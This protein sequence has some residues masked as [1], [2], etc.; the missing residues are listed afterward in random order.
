[1][2]EDLINEVEA[3]VS[4]YGGYILTRTNKEG[5]YIL[6][7]PSHH[8]SLRLCFPS[9]YPDAPP[10]I[11]GTESVGEG[12]RKGYG[13][14]VLQLAR[15]VLGR[16]WQEGEVCLFDLIEELE[17]LLDGEEESPLDTTIHPDETT[18]TENQR[19]AVT[20][21]DAIGSEPIWTLSAPF[22]E[23]KSLFIARACA[24][25]SPTEAQSNITHLLATDKK[26]AKAT[27]NITA[28]RIRTPAPPHSTTTILA[29]SASS[30][31]EITYQDCNNDG[32]TAAG[33]R[34]LHLMQVMDVWGVLIVVSRW[35]GG[36]KLGPD[37]FRIIS[38]VARE[39]LVE[40]GWAAEGKEGKKGR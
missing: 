33:G 17:T 16:V 21:D 23:K 13:S 10:E 24:V 8:V 37:R 7:I 5:L 19:P 2:S 39:V 28:Y 11:L 12:A 14:H 6:S 29:Q 26:M 34:L 35:Y 20:P 4:I 22:T 31:R 25:S 1:M 27:H 32:E 3:I 40:G 18:E 30:T 15:D 38:A 9:T 36:V